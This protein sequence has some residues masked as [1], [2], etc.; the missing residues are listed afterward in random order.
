MNVHIDCCYAGPGGLDWA[1][2][3]KCVV[4]L[5]GSSFGNKVMKKSKIIIIYIVWEGKLDLFIVLVARIAINQL[6]E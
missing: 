2:E 6:T 3:I 4:S 1:S 5:A